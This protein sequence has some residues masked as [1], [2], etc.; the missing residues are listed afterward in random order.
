[1]KLGSKEVGYLVI[2][3]AIVMSILLVS[4]NNSIKASSSEAC[5]CSAGGELSCPHEANLPYQ[6]YLG[7]LVVLAL[8]GVG[9][10]SIWSSKQK[11]G[12]SSAKKRKIKNLAEDEKKLYSEVEKAHGAIFQSELV[13]KTKLSKVKVSRLLDKLEGRGLIERRRRGMTNLV[14][15]K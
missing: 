15:L 10:F 8:F 1:M 12:V 9:G 11:E 13:E 6:T 2:V 4:F 3:L 5:G 7:G 14:V